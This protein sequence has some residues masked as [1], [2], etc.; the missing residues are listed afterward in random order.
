MNQTTIY[1]KSKTKLI[2]EI[3]KQEFIK[4]LKEPSLMKKLTFSKQEYPD[5]YFHSGL[6]DDK[7][8]NLIENS[9]KTIVN[10]KALKK[11]V[12]SKCKVSKENVSLIYP[13]I[14]IVDKK[15]KEIKSKICD[16]L[17]I[18]E[19]N[20]IIFFTA[21]NFKKSGIKELIEIVHALYYKDFQVI[22]AGDT[23]TINN[24]RFQVSKY[25]TDNKLILVENYAN[26]DDLFFI[27]D[28]FIL[29]TYNKS[30]A[31][32]VLKAMYCKCAV[33]VSFDNHSKELID[34]FS[35]MESPTDRSIP[36][37]VDALLNSKSDLK[38]IKKQ[39]RKI[40]K[41]FTLSKNLEALNTLI[42]SI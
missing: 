36:F 16:D 1:Y 7:S 39:N 22:I 2:E 6:L 24:L 17:N 26:I 34:V 8:I 35:T 38:L 12:L 14:E 21:K 11:E 32:N 5:I 41:K 42:H 10:S 20:K 9:K 15:S 30:F 13:S 23:T 40:A 37:K 25:N 18:D 27:S 4:T 29:P 28:V 19:K 3:E 33:F 31:S